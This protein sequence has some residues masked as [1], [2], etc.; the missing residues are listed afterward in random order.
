MRFLLLFSALAVLTSCSSGRIRPE[1][2]AYAREAQYQSLVAYKI[3]SDGNDGD[4]RR[5][6]A[7]VRLQDADRKRLERLTASQ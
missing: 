4:L 2:L 5:C 7:L 6:D 3:C 1:D